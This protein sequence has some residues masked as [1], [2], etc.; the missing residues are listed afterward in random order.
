MIFPKSF[1][2]ILHSLKIQDKNDK[3]IGKQCSFELKNYKPVDKD[4]YQIKPGKPDKHDDQGVWIMFNNKKGNTIDSFKVNFS[5]DY[6][7]HAITIEHNGN[8]MHCKVSSPRTDIILY[9]DGSFECKPPVQIIPES[10][11]ESIYG[12][13][14]PTVDNY[15]QDIQILGDTATMADG[16]IVELKTEYGL[17]DALAYCWN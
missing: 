5:E 9:E 17:K 10:E 11:V 1:N 8:V 13:S 16:T 3:I 7:E 6:K 14:H 15:G 4:S 12:A 2:A